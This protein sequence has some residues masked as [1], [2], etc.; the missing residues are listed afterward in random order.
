[1]GAG[2]CARKEAAVTRPLVNP[3]DSAETNPLPKVSSARAWTSLVSAGARAPMGFPKATPVIREKAAA[4]V[5][6]RR[7]RADGTQEICAEDIMLI[8][9]SPGPAL[10]LRGATVPPPRAKLPSSEELGDGD[11]VVEVA[12]PEPEDFRPPAYSIHAT[13]EILADDVLEVA[14]APLPPPPAPP[15]PHRDE[16]PSTLP[17]TVDA[18]DD[19]DFP[20]PPKYSGPY[21]AVGPRITNFSAT[22]VFRRRSINLKVVVVS[23]TLAAGVV[24]VSGISRLA[25]GSGSSADTSGP[26]GIAMHAPKSLDTTIRTGTL[27]FGF[28]PHVEETTAVSI[29]AL[30]EVRPHRTWRRWRRQR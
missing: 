1:V 30:P 11:I 18:A 29:D 7:I 9:P 16:I 24:L 21:P 25:Q 2:N 28:A 12:A 20:T 26:I 6:P 19:L 4:P 13:Q 27:A 15:P 14:E 17:W 23:M 3:P 8:V 10:S 22:Q 5:P